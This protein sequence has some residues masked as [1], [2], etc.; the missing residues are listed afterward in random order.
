MNVGNNNAESTATMKLVFVGVWLENSV[1]LKK[2]WETSY[3]V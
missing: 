1:K 2:K 3:T